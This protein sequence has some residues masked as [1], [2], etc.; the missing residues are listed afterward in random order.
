VIINFKAIIK[1]KYIAL[2]NAG[3][4][5][6]RKRLCKDTKF[7]KSGLVLLSQ[8]NVL[9][10]VELKLASIMTLGFVIVA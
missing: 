1:I 10:D 5:Q 6:P 4:L 8:E 2:L 3:L 7:Q 9:V